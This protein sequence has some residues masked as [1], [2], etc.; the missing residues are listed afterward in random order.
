MKDIMVWIGIFL[1]CKKIKLAFM[2]EG[3]GNCI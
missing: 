2:P 3:N 1:F